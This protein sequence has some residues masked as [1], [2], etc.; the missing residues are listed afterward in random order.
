MAAKFQFVMRAGPNVGKVFPL[1]PK[2]LLV[3]RDS[4]CAI[5]VI[6]PEVSRKHARLVWQG[7]DF[8]LE[9]LGSTNGTFIN[10]KR[11]NTPYL[12]RAGDT[13]AFGENVALSYEAVYD[14]DA[15][16]VSSSAKLEDIKM[17]VEQPAP[18]ISPPPIYAGHV[19]AGPEPVAVQPAARKGIK[20]WL[21]VVI[22]LVILMCA[23]AGFFII[24]DQLN[25]WCTFFPFLFPGA[26]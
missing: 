19:P 23:C 15:T 22:A 14:P 10:G 8:T 9:D 4:A 26:C 16:M 20:P 5:S 11:I 3:G 1:E 25:L 24:I 21:I 6:D 7:E 17:P 18:I 13:V 2:E 12:L